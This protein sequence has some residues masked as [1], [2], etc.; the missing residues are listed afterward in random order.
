[1]WILIGALDIVHNTVP[2][3]GEIWVYYPYVIM[4]IITVVTILSGI[5]YFVASRNVLKK[6]L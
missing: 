1:M 2:N 4:S 6:Y 3:W 5:D